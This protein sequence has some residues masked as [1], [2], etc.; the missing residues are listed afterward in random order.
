MTP[1]ST[2]TTH[3]RGD[4]PPDQLARGDRHRAELDGPLAVLGR[5]VVVV[6]LE[7]AAGDPELF[8]E[9]VQLVVGLVAD[10]VRP[11]IAP[12]GPDRTIDEDHAGSSSG[13]PCSA[14]ARSSTT[15]W[16]RRAPSSASDTTSRS[17][18]PVRF[19]T[20]AA[21][22]CSTFTR[23]ADTLMRTG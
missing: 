1:L 3:P 10:H 21:S 8:G 23:P 2:S 4:Q 12:V 22:S 6:A 16:P 18:R 20:R 5:H 9:G 19:A 15:P 11:S 17:G 13:G 14:A 7:R